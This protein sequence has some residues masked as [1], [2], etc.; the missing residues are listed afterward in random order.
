MKILVF[1]TLFPNNVWPNHGVFVKERMSAVAGLGGCEVK[2]IAPVPYHPPM[3]VGKRWR[4]SQVAREEVI[5]GIHV[6]HPRYM[7]IP[8]ISMPI[9]G[10]MMFFSVLLLTKRIRRQF[11]FDI[12][13]AHYVYPDG[14]AAVLL[15]RIF[16]KPVMV[17]AR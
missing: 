17:T 4:H 6:Y 2:V 12:I 8:K 9:H 1:T 14:F 11:D 7:L 10:I 15:G 3:R 5:D 16:R 13:D